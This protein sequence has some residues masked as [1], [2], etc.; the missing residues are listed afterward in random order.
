[1]TFSTPHPLPTFAFHHTELHLDT[2][3]H[4]RERYAS[5]QRTPHQNP[6][7]GTRIWWAQTHHGQKR[8]VKEFFLAN[9]AQYTR[10]IPDPIWRN[11][12]P[13]PQAHER[14]LYY[15][16][17][18]S[19]NARAAV[20]LDTNVLQ[21]IAQD[22]LFLEHFNAYS[23]ELEALLLQFSQHY[24]HKQ[25]VQSYR[26]GPI[27]MDESTGPRFAIEMEQLNELPLPRPGD[28]LSITHRLLEMMSAV[29]QLHA[30]MIP[31]RCYPPELVRDLQQARENPI[32]RSFHYDISPDQFMLRPATSHQPEQIVL[33]DFNSSRMNHAEC[34][35]FFWYA[36]PGKEYY[37]PPERRSLQ[38]YRQHRQSFQSSPVYDLYALLVIA[39]F[40]FF[41]KQE[42]QTEPKHIEGWQSP[43]QFRAWLRSPLF[44]THLQAHLSTRRIIDTSILFDL[45][46]ALLPHPPLERRNA[47]QSLSSLRWSG[48]H[49]WMLVPK[50][51]N[52]IARNTLQRTFSVGWKQS[53]LQCLEGSS[54]IPL[55]DWLQPS[56]CSWQPGPNEKGRIDHPS[57]QLDDISYIQA[58]DDYPIVRHGILE[59][60]QAGQYQIFPVWRGCVDFEHPLHVTISP[61][62]SV[63]SSWHDLGST[64]HSDPHSDPHSEHPW[65][66]APSPLSLSTPEHTFLEHTLVQPSV[67]PFSAQTD[68]LVDGEP[69]S[70]HPYPS[71]SY[72]PSYP[73]DH[74]PT[75]QDIP[76]DF[77]SSQPPTSIHSVTP[78]ATPKTTDFSR[79]RHISS[80]QDAKGFSQPDRPDRPDQ[81]SNLHRHSILPPPS[82]HDTLQN[83]TS[84][85]SG[86]LSS[87]GV[88]IL[89][90][91]K[92]PMPWP[93]QLDPL[94]A[95]SSTHRASWLS[96]ISQCQ[97]IARLND[98]EES[99]TSSFAQNIPLDHQVQ[100]YA[101][102][103]ELLLQYRLATLDTP[104]LQHMMQLL[105][106]SDISKLHQGI[107]INNLA[108]YCYQIAWQQRQL[109]DW[110]PLLGKD[111]LSLLKHWL[112]LSEPPLPMTPN[113]PIKHL[114]D[115]CRE[116]LKC[117]IFI[118]QAVSRKSQ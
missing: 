82:P 104:I 52:A 11:F 28:W 49:D 96:A 83:L 22:H 48:L 115:R 41:R 118:Q 73:A 38:E 98:I 27:L 2:E 63:S 8:C 69:S 9:P 116:T 88:E 87:V 95:T 106:R 100:L 79:E 21:S 68:E 4:H 94:Y 112:Q 24:G 59:P 29:T 19:Y 76:V 81:T 14:G 39:L 75:P 47:L 97:D 36:I 51:M 18:Q 26:W 65:T 102:Y 53:S 101:R 1:M 7:L 86:T 42:E 58:G 37:H 66:S 5:L 113:H 13:H 62:A 25:L 50:A 6:R 71:P 43:E 15:Q 3:I 91:P 72:P 20:P 33:L 77:F 35:N 23:F 70:L 93:A 99:M 90:V 54:P 46:K 80:S 78:A 110:E 105:Q 92:D 40:C 61:T 56:R 84:L 57:L 34:H 117:A 30:M 74:H 103:C 109:P 60:A 45:W 32:T 67:G 85:P 16:R 114:R 55:R 10:D 44:A 89:A 17:A 107:L 108:V 31:V 111:P 12:S 64:S